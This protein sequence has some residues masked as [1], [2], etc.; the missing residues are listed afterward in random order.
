MRWFAAGLAAVTLV[1][2]ARVPTPPP[3]VNTDAE[4]RDACAPVMAALPDRLL[5]RDRTLVDAQVVRWGTDLF[6]ACGVD[7]PTELTPVSRCDVIDG[8]GWFAQETSQGWR[9]TTIERDVSVQVIVGRDYAPAADALVDVADAVA[10]LPATR[11][12]A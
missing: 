8:V 4:T 5:D 12:C 6:V 9:F 7:R 3:Q 1:G 2:C 11:P 10:L